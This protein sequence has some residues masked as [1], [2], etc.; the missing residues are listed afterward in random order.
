MPIV[1]FST[2]TL[3]NDN[4]ECWYVLVF[5][6][7]LGN[8]VFKNPCDLLTG[9]QIDMNDHIDWT[10]FDW[11]Q[12]VSS[13]LLNNMLPGYF[14]RVNMAGTCI[15]WVDP[16]SLSWL[17]DYRVRCTAN[18]TE[19]YLQQKVVGTPNRI[20]VSLVPG[21]SQH[22][23]VDIHPDFKN[24]ILPAT[25][26]CVD[27]N[28]NP[29]GYAQLVYDT[30]SWIHR[31]CQQ[32][33]GDRFWYQRYLSSDIIIN[34]WD[35]WFPAWWFVGDSSYWFVD[36]SGGDWLPSMNHTISGDVFPLG[37]PSGTN[38]PAIEIQESGIYAVWANVD[39][40]LT[41]EAVRAIRFF[42]YSNNSKVILVNMKEADQELPLVPAGATFITRNFSWYNQVYLN[43]WEY[44]FLWVRVYTPDDTKTFSL[45]ISSQA[46]ELATPFPV[47]IAWR[48]SGTTFGCALVSKST[49]DAN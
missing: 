33:R 42:V 8:F 9:C 47:S 28:Y 18:D 32:N 1:D 20:I 11:C 12:I 3:N 4:A 36:A 25:P 30:T 34:Q 2:Y 22:L 49:Q 48:L 40:V 17:H 23:Q 39:F 14:L 37:F 6:C 21:V 35:T 7:T 10:T 27:T 26:T 46:L 5:D 43:K 38:I 31:E 16:T 44:L 13:P 24:S 29:T 45:R 19:D 41:G 15:E